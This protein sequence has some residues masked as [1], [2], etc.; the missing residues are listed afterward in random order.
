[1][2]KIFGVVAIVFFVQMLFHSFLPIFPAAAAETE[3]RYRYPKCVFKEKFQTPLYIVFN[4]ESSIGARSVHCLAL[5]L[6]LSIDKP[7]Q[8]IAVGDYHTKYIINADEA[9]WVISEKKRAPDNFRPMQAFGRKLDAEIF[10]KNK[11]GKLATF[12]EAL[13]AAFDDINVNLQEALTK[14]KNNSQ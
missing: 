14:R 2:K 10:I 8:S 12:D 5:Y 11:G 6:A 4:D 3:K 7:I 1:M 13:K 9:Y